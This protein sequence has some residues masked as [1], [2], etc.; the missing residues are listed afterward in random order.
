MA[1]G[2]PGHCT[3]AEPDPNDPDMEINTVNKNQIIQDLTN[4]M[5]M[6]RGQLNAVQALEPR[7]LYKFNETFRDYSSGTRTEGSTETYG[8]VETFS[9]ESVRFV[10]IAS[11]N[12][13][14]STEKDRD[15]TRKNI[16]ALPYITTSEPSWKIHCK[17]SITTTPLS[18]D[19]TPVA[20]RDLPL[21]MG[22]KFKSTEYEMI[23]KG[24]RKLK[25]A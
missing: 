7:K 5:M 3:R 1:H 19:L 15:G 18:D 25:Y 2:L 17:E 11:N 12:P 22:M 4:K 16:V 20:E 21:L 8:Y 14:Y 23:L 13:K 24:K 9:R 6:L 10:V